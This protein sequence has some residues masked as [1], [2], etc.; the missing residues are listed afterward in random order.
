MADTHIATHTGLA[1]HFDDIEQQRS[2]ETLTDSAVDVLRSI[3]RSTDYAW[4]RE[5]AFV[6]AVSKTAGESIV[7]TREAEA[8]AAALIG[9][10]SGLRRVV[11]AAAK[12]EDAATELL[13]RMTASTHPLLLVNEPFDTAIARVLA[14][15]GVQPFLTQV[16]MVRGVKN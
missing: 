10:S 6:D 9:S 7:I 16:E 1:H 2:R 13:A 5:S 4:Q 11:H 14:R 15:G 3:S 8:V 12:D